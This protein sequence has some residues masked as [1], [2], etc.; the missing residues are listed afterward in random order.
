MNHEILRADVRLRRVSVAVL[1]LAAIVALI[2]MFAF[3]YWLTRTA[4]TM[5]P[6]QL[7]VQLRIW[8]GAAL[9]ACGVCIL[10][11]A[12]LAARLARRILEQRRWPLHGAR[13]LQDTPIRRDAE[14]ANIARKMNV[15]ALLLMALAASLGALSWHLFGSGA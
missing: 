3:R 15:A 14:A 7:I 9:V 2:L 5:P 8:I 11:L 1:A 10:A 6:A 13:V 4:D 12:G